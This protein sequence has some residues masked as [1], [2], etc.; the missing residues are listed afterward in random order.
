MK[1]IENCGHGI[2]EL[3][4]NTRY[5]LVKCDVCGGWKIILESNSNN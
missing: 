1:A 5:L 2:L 4:E 3:E